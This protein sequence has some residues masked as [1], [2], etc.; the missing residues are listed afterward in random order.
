MVP[1]SQEDV[2]K[3]GDS[4]GSRSEQQSVL[5]APKHPPPARRPGRQEA[6]PTDLHRRRA[7]GQALMSL[8]LQQHNE[9]AT[10]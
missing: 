7:T 6:N 4:Q 8:K 1:G 9:D 5:N 3:S 2:D 10:V